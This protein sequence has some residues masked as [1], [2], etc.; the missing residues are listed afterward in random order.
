MLDSDLDSLDG[1]NQGSPS[2]DSDSSREH[3]VI[4]LECSAECSEFWDEDW[5]EKEY[6]SQFANCNE[7]GH[8]WAAL[9]REL[10]TSRRIKEDDPWVSDYFDFDALLTGLRTGERISMPLLD[11]G[12]DPTLLPL[13]LMGQSLGA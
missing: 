3:G 11:D 2:H 8:V 13:W 10:L 7:L 9:Q 6:T 4:P 1:I 12:N 5:D